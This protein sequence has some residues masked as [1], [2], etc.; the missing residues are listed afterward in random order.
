MCSLP[1][2][3][4]RLHSAH[5]I[6]KV[7]GSVSKHFDLLALVLTLPFCCKFKPSRLYVET[8]WFH[9]KKKS[10]ILSTDIMV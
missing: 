2:Q 5:D 10:K 3:G 6:V 7:L 1:L 4:T 9:F 8:L